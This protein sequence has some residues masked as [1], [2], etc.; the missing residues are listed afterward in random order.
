MPMYKESPGGQ[1]RYSW[2][3][4]G[5]DGFGLSGSFSVPSYHNGVILEDEKA[6]YNNNVDKMLRL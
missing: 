3:R 6:I 5:L 2:T 1:G 4:K